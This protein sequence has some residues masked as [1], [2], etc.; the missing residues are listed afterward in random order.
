MASTPNQ[1]AKWLPRI[2]EHQLI[3]AMVYDSKG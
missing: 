1:K 2:A 3:Q